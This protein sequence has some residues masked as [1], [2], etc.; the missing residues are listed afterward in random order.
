MNIFLYKMS[1]LM[2]IVYRN[3]MLLEDVNISRLMT[4]AQQVE[5][6][7]IMEHAMENKKARAGNYDFS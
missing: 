6:Y 1:D 5:G 7:K 3:V 4:H 2:K